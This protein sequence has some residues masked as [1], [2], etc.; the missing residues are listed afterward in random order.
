MFTLIIY[1]TILFDNV[2]DLYNDIRQYTNDINTT[3]SDI[4]RDNDDNGTLFT[5]SIDSIKLC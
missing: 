5:Q 4:I 1:K 3:F 2:Y